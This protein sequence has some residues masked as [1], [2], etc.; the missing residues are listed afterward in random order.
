VWAIN[1][2]ASIHSSIACLIEGFR[3]GS[4]SSN[5]QDHLQQDIHSWALSLPVKKTSFATAIVRN[6]IVAC[7]IS[8]EHSLHIRILPLYHAI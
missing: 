2:E 4:S 1:P 7:V 3:G 6:Y 8:N 5:N